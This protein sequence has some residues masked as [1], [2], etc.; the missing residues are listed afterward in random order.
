MRTLHDDE[1]DADADADDDR[2]EQPQ[3][4]VWGVES[5]IEGSRRA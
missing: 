4:V 2:D 5:S 1:A 3:R